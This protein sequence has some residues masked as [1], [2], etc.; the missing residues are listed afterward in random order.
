MLT[1]GGAIMLALGLASGGFLVAAPLGL[2][3]P[4]PGVL[5]WVLFPAF[6]IIGYL[7]LAFA[8]RAGKMPALS[9]VAGV[10]L[11]LL[12]LGAAVGLFLCANTLVPVS[13]S[14]LALWYVLG[15][16][17]VAS[18]IGLSMGEPPPHV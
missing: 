5:A 7:L 11:M 15:I 16:G 2:M 4:E 8:A 3:K 9:R 17:I 14:T 18:A 6:T 10:V 1:F 12:A 13:G